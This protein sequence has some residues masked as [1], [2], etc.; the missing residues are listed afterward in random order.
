MREA[1]FD[2]NTDNRLKHDPSVVDVE[3]K[4]DIF[5]IQ[6]VVPQEIA[7]KPINIVTAFSHI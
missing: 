5:G 7:Q 2:C 1:K 3:H 4:D 6:A